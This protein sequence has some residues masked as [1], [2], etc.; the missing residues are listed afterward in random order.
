MS[1]PCMQVTDGISIPL[2]E[3]HMKVP[4]PLHVT[5]IISPFETLTSLDS[6]TSCALLPTFKV[7]W[8]LAARKISEIKCWVYCSYSWVHYC[9]N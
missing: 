2:V 6:G 5:V 1:S 4:D 3:D 8:S 7:S 9:K